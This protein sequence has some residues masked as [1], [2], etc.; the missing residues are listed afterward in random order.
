[1]E[2][3]YKNITISGKIAV[4]T[5]TLAKN[6]SK[7]IGWKHVNA[8]F[9]Q[10][11]YDRKNHIHENMQGA[12]A[13]SD[14]HEKGIEAMTK[15]LLI[16]KHHLV[17][18]AWLSGFVARKIPQVLKILVVCSEDAIRVDRVVNRENISVEEAKQW[19][20]QREEENINKWKKL[21]GD[22]DFWDRKYYDLVID[23][24][25]SGRL[26]TLGKVLDKLGFPHDNLS[27]IVT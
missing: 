4:G 13:R 6:L 14:E 26:E 23:T 2:L 21:Y 22:Y 19:I 16:E 15:R 7:I 9:I 25:S 8:G 24:Y 18:E 17:Y 10:R 5:T 1:M 20:K 27:T 3:S 11:E 12:S